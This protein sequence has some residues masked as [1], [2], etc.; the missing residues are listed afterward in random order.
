M[1][2]FLF[3]RQ[4][5]N[6]QNPETSTTL[7]TRHRTKIK[8]TLKKP[9]G[10]IKNGQNP[11]TST[12]LGTR[13]RTR[14][15]KKQTNKTP[16]KPT[17]QTNKVYLIKSGIIS[18]LINKT[19]EKTEGTMMNGQ[20]R[21]AGSIWHNNPEALAAFGTR[22]E[23]KQNKKNNTENKYIH[24]Q[25][26]SWRYFLFYGHL[27]FYSTIYHPITTS[28]NLKYKIKCLVNCFIVFLI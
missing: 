11:E 3:S 7:G 13:H 8:K 5:T 28:S 12:T 17:K 21:D 22:L 26:I 15:K 27:S 16:K 23:D 6:D 19:L 2:F 24:Q 1:Q 10:E 4:I 20:S 25:F 18:C 9:D 14:I